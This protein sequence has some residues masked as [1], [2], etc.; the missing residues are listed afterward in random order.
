[1]GE[2]YIQAMGRHVAV[3]FAYVALTVA[4]TWP[5]AVHLETAVPHDLGDPLLSTWTLWWNASVLPLTERW[6]NGSIF[7]PAPDALTLSDHRLGIGL[8]TTPVIWLGMSPLVAYNLAFLAS[9]ILC[10]IGGYALGFVL[11]RHHGAALLAGLVFGFNP[12]RAAHLPHLELLCSYW[13]PVALLALHRWGETRKPVWLVVLSVALTLQALTSVYYFAFFGVVVGLW[14]L[15]FV[16][17][18]LRPRDYVALGASLAAPL[19][20][21]APILLQYRRAHASMGLVRTIDEI[22]YFSAD[23]IGLITTPQ[24]LALWNSPLSWDKGEGAIYPGVIAVALVVAGVVTRGSPPAPPW[25]LWG[26]RIRQGFLIGAA[27]AAVAALMPAIWGPVATELLGVRLSISQSFKPTSVALLLVAA[28]LLTSARVRGAWHVHSVLGFYALATVAMWLF[29]LGPTG[30]VMGERFLYKAPYSWLMLLPGVDT[31]LRVP[32]R[33]GM[34][35]AL[36]LC[37]AAALAWGRLTH[38][39]S[40]RWTIVATAFAAVAITADSWIKPLPLPS[41]PSA[42]AIPASAPPDAAVLE[43]PLGVAE[44]AA[45]MYR[46]IRHRRPTLNGLSGYA[47]PSYQVLH[48]AM[49]EGRVDVLAGLTPVAPVLAF[50]DR[51]AAGEHLTGQMRAF[52]SATLLHQDATYDVLLI[53]RLQS[54]TAIGAERDS[55]LPMEAGQASVDA[56]RLE[57]VSDDDRLTRWMTPTQ[58]G[59]EAFTA[60]LGQLRD[61]RGIVLEMG[62]WAGAFPRRVSVLTSATGTEWADAWEGDVAALAL[63][64]ALS[65]QRDVPI[66]VPFSPRSARYVR[67]RQLGWSSL[68]WAVAEF[69]VLVD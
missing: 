45:A 16:R 9:F 66:H 46:A 55:E 53:P 22:E 24:A 8:I 52:P 68:P 17:L 62:P 40:R 11:T 34:L 57:L 64:A 6:W 54:T 44:D 13:L 31:A 14:L 35:A 48:A 30:R 38:G 37:A 15:W 59:V 63:Q 5:L 26:R 58:Q 41:A 25:P 3:L 32:A 67:V 50:V 10:A 43:L 4:L 28:W 27:I 42:L 47:P 39:R 19:F 33:F 65:N 1:M 49:R 29:A 2:R 18:R 7:F 12:F 60:D 56:D 51:R 23:L 61:V 21:I 36:T 69:R 20:I